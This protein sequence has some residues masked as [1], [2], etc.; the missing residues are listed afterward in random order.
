[1]KKRLFLLL[2]LLALVLFLAWENFMGGNY[3]DF[4]GSKADPGIRNNNPTNLR[5]GAALWLGE[6]GIDYSSNAGGYIIFSNMYFGLRAGAINLIHYFTKHGWNT[7]AKIAQA[8]SPSSD[9]NDTNGKA[10]A[11]AKA[12]GVGVNDTLHV[13]SQGPIILR[14]IVVTELKAGEPDLISEKTY[15]DAWKNAVAYTGIA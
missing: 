8:W 15:S 14:T 1:M 13:L 5:P 2:A 9:G 3:E 11:I 12:L 6:V 10:L 7:P 4:R